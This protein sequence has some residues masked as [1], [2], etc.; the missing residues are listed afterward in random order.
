MKKYVAKATKGVGWRVWNRKTKRWWGN[1]FKYYPEALL[2]E[3][4]GERRP[5]KITELSKPS[6]P[7][8][9]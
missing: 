7:H 4:N 1:F 6:R 3:L 5:D 9:V 2:E 8:E